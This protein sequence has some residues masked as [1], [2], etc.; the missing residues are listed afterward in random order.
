MRQSGYRRIFLLMQGVQLQH[1]MIGK[2]LAAKRQE[3]G[4]DRILNGIGPVNERQ[5]VRRNSESH[6]SGSDAGLQIL[7]K[8]VW[9]ECADGV[10]K[11]A[12]V[13]DCVPLLRSV[14]SK[15]LSGRLVV[16][17]QGPPVV[18]LA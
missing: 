5:Q 11:L 7:V 6:G 16:G 15:L 2:L 9:H 17:R 12:N 4:P 3:L 8:S 1:R 13:G 14:I 10:A 18:A